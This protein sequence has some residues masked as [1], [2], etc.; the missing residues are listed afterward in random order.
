MRSWSVEDAKVNL[1]EIIGRALAN[2][3]QRL[4]QG[5]DCVVVV[6]AREYAAMAFARDLIAFVQRAGVRPTVDSQP[7]DVA[8]PDPDAL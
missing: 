6:S 5:D 1:G 2:K 3:P 8:R 4:G 7:V